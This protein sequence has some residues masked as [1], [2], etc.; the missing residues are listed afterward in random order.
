MPKEIIA[1]PPIFEKRDILDERTALIQVA[2]APKR[3]KTIE[4]PVT[5]KIEL[6]NIISMQHS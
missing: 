3:I 2:D 4:K 1:S 5:K 6:I